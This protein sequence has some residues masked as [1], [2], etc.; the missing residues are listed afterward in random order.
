MGPGLFGSASHLVGEVSPSN[1]WL[2]MMPAGKRDSPDSCFINPIIVLSSGS[3]QCDQRHHRRSTVLL[4][5]YSFEA[6]CS[7]FMAITSSTCGD[8]KRLPLQLCSGWGNV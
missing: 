4:C 6:I 8:T 7:C 3:K 5:R 2:I 1:R